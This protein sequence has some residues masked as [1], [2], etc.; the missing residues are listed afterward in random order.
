[1]TLFFNS[2]YI[3]GVCTMSAKK[4]NSILGGSSNIVI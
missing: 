3:F 1:M 4:S 2:P